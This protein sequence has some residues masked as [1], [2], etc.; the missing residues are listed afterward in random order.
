MSISEEHARGFLSKDT[1]KIPVLLEIHA[2][3]EIRL[4][5]HYEFGMGNLSDIRKNKNLIRFQLQNLK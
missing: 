3:R 1:E 2:K 4:R 5:P